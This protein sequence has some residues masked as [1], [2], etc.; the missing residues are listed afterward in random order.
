MHRVV[1]GTAGHIDHGKTRL[2]EALTGI[3]C[4]RWREEKERGI[5]IDLGFAHL[6]DGDLQVGFVDV[7]GHERFLHNALVGL[8]GIRVV[9]LVVAADE[10]VMPQTREHLDICRLLE[11][12]S[13]VVAL[14]KSDLVDDDMLML[15]QLEIEELL[16]GDRFEGAPI[17]PVSSLTGDGIEDLKA[18]LLAQCRETAV[19]A[20]PTRPF[21]LP[22]DRAFQLRGLGVV[23]TG[24]PVAGR[25]ESG[26]SLELQ[27]ATKAGRTTR[28][29]HAVRVRGIQVHDQD[30]G[31]ALAG[32]RTALQLGGV[33][34]DDLERGQQLVTSEVLAPARDLLLRVRWLDDAPT[35][36][37]TTWTEMRFHLF[38]SEVLGRARCLGRLPAPDGP[39]ALKDGALDDGS[40]EPGE[41]GVVELRLG[42]PV[43]A[44]RGD[45][46]ILRRPSPGATLGGGVVLDPRWRRRR[47]LAASRAS[48]RRLLDDDSMLDAWC[49]DAGAVGLGA[50]DIAARLGL[51][52]A[53][54]EKALEQRVRD[55]HL[56][57]LRDRCVHPRVV[58]G[59]VESA[60]A[61]LDEFFAAQRLAPGMPKA[62]LIARLLPRR[63][64]GHAETYL[65]WLAA[66]KVL[67]ADGDLVNPPG[68]SVAEAL[69]H[70]ESDLSRTLLAAI[71]AE[72]LT[73]PSPPELA[74][75]LGVKPQILDG[76]QTYLITQ[77]RLVRLPSGL[78]VSTTAIERLR[79]ELHA[80]GWQSFSVPEFKDRWELS[81]K[82]AIPLLE[83][84]DSIGVTRRVGDRRQVVAATSTH[85]GL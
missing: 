34:L 56:L 14:T 78:I 7:P 23:V 33:E 39:D 66:A 40:L 61:L 2:L 73:P 52:R 58:Q 53:R 67:L 25:V 4:D 82:W 80:A 5:T 70:E 13:A 36:L 27:P 44:V 51:R 3:D 42:R 68:R 46:F 79:D 9:L 74:R 21:R 37:G 85:S 38:A 57:K 45:R 11:I 43:V 19:D 22:I 35:P 26:Q 50:D 31:E 54:A 1:V 83:H 48:A 75:R 30:R 71:E 60:R 76:V 32:E 47:N 10:G 64:R 72:G 65:R 81:R 15:A 17:L 6:E 55:G 29:G 24:T 77:R 69:S 84:L 41:V 59:L 12:D 18:A 62:E 49:H 20:D 28:R 63:A 8:G 16:A